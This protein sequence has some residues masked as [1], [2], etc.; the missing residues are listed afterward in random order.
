MEAATRVT[1]IGPARMAGQPAAANQHRRCR[2][3]PHD[4][5]G[6]TPAQAALEATRGFGGGRGRHARRQRGS[7][8]QL[9]AQPEVGHDARGLVGA[10]RQIGLDLNAAAG[11]QLVV[12]IGV[13]V[14]LDDGVAKSVHDG[15]PTI[16]KRA[17]RPGSALSNARSAARAR[18]MRD[19]S[20]PSGMS[21]A[22]AAS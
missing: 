16:L 9:V 8:P 22:E 11:I 18:P 14:G 1:A 20:V 5:Q 10:G 15:P 17:G 7:E 4:V 21:S 13:E 3:A 6:A 19:I 2:E 12:H